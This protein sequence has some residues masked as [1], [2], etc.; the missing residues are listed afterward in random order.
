MEVELGRSE[1]GG[2]AQMGFA[3]ACQV[4][5]VQAGVGSRR[6][7]SRQLVPF[8]KPALEI[9]FLDPSGSGHHLADVPAYRGKERSSAGPRR[10]KPHRFDL[11]TRCVV[12]LYL[13]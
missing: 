7:P 1:V 5:R 9:T 12:T 2:C 4:T 10:G 3:S 8:R 13:S 6:D 11:A